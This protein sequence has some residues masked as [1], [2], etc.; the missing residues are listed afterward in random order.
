MIQHH[1][2]IFTID[3]L[4]TDDELNEWLTYI[5]DTSFQDTRP[6]TNAAFN[7]G[8]VIH[9]E[10]SSRIY[11]RIAPHLP[12]KRAV[13]YI[14]FSHIQQGQGFGI[15]TDTGCEYDPEANEMSAYTVLI[16]LNDD[17][18][19]G[20]TQF[21]TENFIPTVEIQPKKGRTLIF[22]IDLFHKGNPVVEGDK[23]WIGT[24]LVDQIHRI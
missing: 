6:F 2:D 17:F 14:M 9:P 22:H 1:T 20:T 24:E 4:F 15:H 11:E 23:Y 13:K 10:W 7:N 12:T 16:Y 8:K 18:T 19:G 5:K 21:Y 3:D